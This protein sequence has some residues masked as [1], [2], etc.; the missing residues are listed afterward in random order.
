VS[1]SPEHFNTLTPELNPSAQRCLPNYLLGILIVKG[2]TARL[3]YKSFGV[4]GF[5]DILQRICLLELSAFL[6]Q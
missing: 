3:L 5:M 1:F 6:P 2:L 4:K